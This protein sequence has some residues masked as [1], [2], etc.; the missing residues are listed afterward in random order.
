MTSS[1][2]GD[3]TERELLAVYHVTCH[4]GEEIRDK[5]RGIALEQSVELPFACVP[6][7]HHRMIPEE[8][9]LE[10]EGRG[11]RLTLAYPAELLGGELL[12]MLN[13]LFGNISLKR[14]I[15]L[16]D[17]RWPA[18]LPGGKSLPGPRYGVSG[19]RELTGIEDRALTCTALK[20]VGS[21]TAELAGACAAFARGGIDLIKDDHG[22]ANQASAPFDERLAR[23]QEA[24]Q[25]HAPAWYV[26]N[27]TAGRG[28]LERRTEAAVN[29]GCRMVLVC[30]FLT[31]LD[32]LCALRRQFPV[33]IMAHPA[34]AGSVAGTDHGIAPDLLLGELLRLLGADA[35]IYPNT[36]GRFPTYDAALCERIIDRLRRPIAGAE[37]TME[38]AWPTPGGGVDA[39]RVAE[40]NAR[41]G[42]DTIFLVGGSL[43]AQGDLEAASRRFRAAVE[44]E[45]GA[46]GSFGPAAPDESAPPAS[47][48]VREN[49]FRWEDVP[50]QAYKL[51]TGNFHGVV[52]QVLVGERHGEE[53][54]G[55]VT[56]YFEIEPGGYTS[57]ERHQH[58]HVVVILR[59]RAE[60]VLD[61]RVEAATPYDAVFI[62][63][64][65]LHQL[66]AASPDEPMGF[67][68]IVDR[69]RDAPSYPDAEE[70]R[71]LGRSVDIAPRP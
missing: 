41:Y 47:R 49:E 7:A 27:V 51:D 37:V 19:L 60:I 43:Y 42:R 5:A 50:T 15:R 39:S 33:A 52:R 58:P 28:E 10:P 68:C 71:E 44:P 1:T 21:S 11:Y 32:A 25:A 45:A 31:G 23:C 67:L 22:L 61:D 66:R 48:V 35:V 20:P 65:C 3:P 26:P 24:A 8:R 16:V 17:V 13:V 36:G 30:P 38:P 9:S 64:G 53:A 29:A 40:W 54:P 55:F 12:Q 63:P 56:R 34:F 14:G 18:G 2:A 59:G 70:L 62:A 6:E 46:P 69:H 4:P 57:L